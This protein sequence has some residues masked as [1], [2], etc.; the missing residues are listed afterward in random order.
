MRVGVVGAGWSGLVAAAHLASEG[1]DVE[2]LEA[3]HRPGGRIATVSTQGY[4]IEAGPHA[5]V[6]DAFG[7]RLI[8]EAGLDADEAPPRAPRY[9]V[10]R[11]RLHPV[12]TSPARFLMTP[13]LSPWAKLRLLAEPLV[14]RREHPESIR[15]FA[16]R[17]FGRGVRHVVDAIVTGSSAGDP[18]RIDVDDAFPSLR[19]MERA[20][21][22]LRNLARA[23]ERGGLLA[24]TGGM[25][26]LVER[27]AAKARVRYAE[28]VTGS[29]ETD[30][31][32]EL[33]TDGATR[34]YDRVL[35]AC[36]PR[37]TL[38]LLGGTSAI[39]PPVA[40]IHV[41]TFGVPEAH[42]PPFAYG[43]LAAEVEGRF[44]LGAIFESHLFP[45]RAPAGHH[46]V[47][48]LLGGRRHPERAGLPE[49]QIADLAWKDLRDVGAVAGEP[50][51]THHVRTQGI[52]QLEIGRPSVTGGPSRRIGVIGGGHRASGLTALAT[53]AVAE[54]DRL[55]RAA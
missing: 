32:V 45:G 53:Q 42:A 2:I 1:H 25:G 47:R 22:V 49:A 23:K 33:T 10:H 55:V 29:K 12:P 5:L 6:G 19:E 8:A 39:L 16:D 51:F 40:P 4:L 11:G 38:P 18:A 48:C 28:R 41:V 52:P 24:P 15:S 26:H 27:L 7:R 36:E 13:L 21:G 17:R 9:L 43:Y 34:A 14:P 54:A 50:A 35:V 31:A 30:A 20:G 37:A 3:G 46:L 44:L